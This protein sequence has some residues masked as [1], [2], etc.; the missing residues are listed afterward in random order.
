M[1]AEL[2]PINGDPPIPLVR[3]VTIVGRRDFCDV[4]IDH[5]SL[6]KRHC[7]LVKTDGLVVVRDLG[8]TNGTRVNGQRVRWAALLPKDRL[9]IGR[10]QVRIYLGPDH[11]PAPSEQAKAGPAA[12][13]PAPPTPIAPPKAPAVQPVTVPAPMPAARVPILLT[14]KDVVR[15]SPETMRYDDIDIDDIPMEALVDEDDDE[16]PTVLTESDMLPPS[17]RRRR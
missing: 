7:V 11:A 1:K 6:S 2:V 5:P 12:V 10:Y 3:D 17:S 8:S 15:V 14:E 16:M 4:I 13:A 9:T